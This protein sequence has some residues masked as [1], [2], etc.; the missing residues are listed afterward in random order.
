MPE[1]EP[2]TALPA[3]LGVKIDQLAGKYAADPRVAALVVGICYRGTTRAFAYGTVRKDGGPPPDEDTLFEIGS[4]TKVFTSTVLA[5]MTC[6]GE[7]RLDDPIQAYLPEEVK[8]PSRDA[9][10]VTLRHLA[11]HTSGLP[12]LPANLAPTDPANPYADYTDDSLHAFLANHRLRRVPGRVSEYSNAGAGLLAHLLGRVAGA[13]YE[14]LVVERLCG[15][16]GMRDTAAQLTPQQ[17]A[18]LAPGHAKGRP[19]PGWTFQA[20]AGA[21]AL[22]S[23]GKDMLRF[24]AANLGHGGESLQEAFELA[25][26]LQFGAPLFVTARYYVVRLAVGLAL[27]VA[28]ASLLPGIRGLV[29]FVVG[30]LLWWLLEAGIG[31]WIDARYQPM[32]LGWHIDSLADGALVRWHNGGTGGYRSYFGFSRADQVGVVVLANNSDR[33]PDGLGKEVIMTLLEAARRAEQALPGPG[34]QA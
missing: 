28:V 15:P 1:I 9:V 16:L 23:S 20:L 29:R 7:V 18:R 2:P 17:Q 6:S 27:A 19:V 34:R 32:A 33:D 8:A 25:Q 24:L 22:R 12:R 10:A 30:L 21:G 26:Q 3:S 13:S 14:A 4:I 5:Q 31:S 11:T